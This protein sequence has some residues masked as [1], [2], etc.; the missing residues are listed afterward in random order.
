MAGEGHIPPVYSPEPLSAAP[1]AGVDKKTKWF[2]VG[3]IR[4]AKRIIQPYIKP[5]WTGIETL[6]QRIDC[7]LDLLNV[8][9]TH[10]GKHVLVIR[11]ANTL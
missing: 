1:V 8:R 9:L 5:Q 11:Y 10:G 3:R 2:L 7:D 6:G 4:E